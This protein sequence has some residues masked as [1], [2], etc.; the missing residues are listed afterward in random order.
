MFERTT[1]LFFFF[2]FFLS[3]SLS[4]VKGF[5]FVYEYSN[6]LFCESVFELFSFERRVRG[7]GCSHGDSTVPK[8]LI[9]MLDHPFSLRCHTLL[10]FSPCPIY[11]PI[12]RYRVG[13]AFHS[14]GTIA[15][16][17]LFFTFTPINII[18]HTT[19]HY[20]FILSS[21][22]LWSDSTYTEKKVKVNQKKGRSR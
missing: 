16:R 12:F 7:L 17:Q 21:A 14:M 15:S 6:L 4:I 20:H 2:F 11:R 5:H 18:P 10:A 19:L 22:V 1:S 9:Y 13:F 3:L 8:R